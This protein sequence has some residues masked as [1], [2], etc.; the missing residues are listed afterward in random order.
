MSA[1]SPA[2]LGVRV[3]AHLDDL[4]VGADTPLVVACSGGLD[5]SVL[6]H[7]LCFPAAH[8][9][10]RI[11]VAHFDHAM[12][13]ESPADAA[14]VRGLARGWGVR[15]RVGR[16]DEPPRTETEART[17]RWRFLEGVADEVSAVGVVTAHHADDQAETVLHHAIRGTGLRGLAGMSARRDGRI[18][19]LLEVRRATLAEY[20]Q[21]IGLRFRVDPTNVHPTTARNRLR[22]EVLPLLEAI[23]PGATGGLVRLARLAG[24]E[25]RAL[26]Q[27]EDRLLESLVRDHTHTRIVVDHVGL[28]DLPTELRSRVLRRLAREVGGRLD[29]AGTRA[30]HAFATAGPGGGRCRLPDGTVVSRSLGALE[31]VGPRASPPPGDRS[32]SIPGPA[33]GVASCVVGG[34]VWAVHWG[35]E[36]PNTRW[37]GQLRL[38]ADAFPVRVRP[39]RAG[40]LFAE[41]SWSESVAAL[42]RRAEVPH[43]ERLRRPVVEDARGRVLWAP[44]TPPWPAA[45]LAPGDPFFI[46]IDHVD[47]L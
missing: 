4:G 10:E 13:P 30:A 23:R 35:P 5:S 19:P 1:G 40:D 11:T 46:G 25:E 6:L 24:A 44:D 7:L 43:F 9:R 37:C 38:A 36:R 28:L 47:D 14:W 33:A 27:A 42:W 41:G 17:A 39:W 22:G 12:R 21:T 20:A 18:R 31:F 26:E 3:R 16:S 15:C 8:L 34:R 29:E 45:P 2:N 32:V